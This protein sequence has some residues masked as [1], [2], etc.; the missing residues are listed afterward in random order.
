V[1]EPVIELV[2][3][4]DPEPLRRAVHELSS[5]QWVL[6]TSQNG[7]ERFFAELA[8]Q[9]GD[10][11]RLGGVRVGAI[12][13]KTAGALDRFAVRADLVASEFV[14]EAFARD[15]LA[16]QR[17]QPGRVLIPRALV[18]RDVLPRLLGERGFTVCVAPSYET[19]VVSEAGRSAIAELFQQRAIDAVVFTSSSTVKN[20]CAA[21]GQSAAEALGQVTV[22]S[23]G[24]V[25]TETAQRLGV[26]V[27]VTA[28]VYTVDGVLDA[29]GQYFL[30]G[31]GAGLA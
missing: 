21:L 6:F 4:P 30:A 16:A 13:Q 24:P 10:T 11:R 5:Y 14:A 2:D 1:L 3:P 9:G 28:S 18:A 26:R 31:A 27:D 23:I 22:G 29:L 15:L 8:R 20:A 25:T 19:R 7:V 12:G 17:G